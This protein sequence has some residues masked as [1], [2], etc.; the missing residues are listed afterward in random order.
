M[1]GLGDCNL[2]GDPTSTKAGEQRQI[3]APHHDREVGHG[4]EAPLPE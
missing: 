3:M 2:C 4:A 1:S